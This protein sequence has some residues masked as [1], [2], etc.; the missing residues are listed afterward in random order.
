MQT[1][2]QVVEYV[3][4]VGRP[5]IAAAVGVSE[6]AVRMASVRGLLSPSWFKPM[7]D[8]KLDPPEELFA[9]SKPQVHEVAPS[10][11]GAA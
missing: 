2:P 1:D 10:P 9:W 7:R 3:A 4:R 6:N 8:A 11:S 5:A